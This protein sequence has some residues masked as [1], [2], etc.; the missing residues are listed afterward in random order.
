MRKTNLILL[1]LLVSVIRSALYAQGCSDAGACTAPGFALHND[2]I[3]TSA[4]INEIRLGF[5]YGNADNAIR[6]IGQY[7]EYHRQLDPL[8]RLSARLSELAQFGNDISTWGP[9]DLFLNGSFGLSNVLSVSAGV[10]LP[11]MQADRSL[12]GLPLPMDYQSSLG[13][14]DLLL[15]LNYR[16]GAWRML[17][18]WQ[19]TLTQNK[20][21]FDPNLYPG[22]S[23]L[24]G[25]ADTRSYSRQGDV[26]LRLSHAFQLKKWTL[27]PG[28]LP[29]YHLGNDSY[30]DDLGTEREIEGSAGLTLNAI[31]YIDYS[32]SRASALQWNFGFPLVVRESR[33]DGLT[34]GFQTSIEYRIRF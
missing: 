21:R 5:S 11:L 24:N 13:T 22:D 32:F 28:I 19:Q 23:P 14:V 1:I 31:A 26:L 33:P 12:N 18:A 15:G 20:N 16:Y 29:I 17:F 8:T 34:R 7:L 3:H 25:F 10:K 27:T 6:V 9:S 2:S 4:V 30:E